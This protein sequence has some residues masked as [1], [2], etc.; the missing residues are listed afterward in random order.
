MLLL[1]QSDECFCFMF[2]AVNAVA[3]GA[4][5]FGVVAVSDVACFAVVVTY[6]CLI[7]LL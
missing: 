6:F 5:D 1:L 3:S 2:F 7:M 4:V